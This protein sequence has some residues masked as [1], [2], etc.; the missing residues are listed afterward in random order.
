[1]KLV[2]RMLASALFACAAA[3]VTTGQ[4]VPDSLTLANAIQFAQ[5]RNPEVLVAREQLAELKGTIQEVRSQAYPDIS[6]QGFGL[7]LRDPSIL[8][9][10]S[11]D[12][13]PDEF[14]SALVPRGANLFDVGVTVKQPLYSAGKV[15]AGIR[16]AE[17]GQREKEA[18]LEA[19]RRNVAFK[20]FQAFHDLLLAQANLNVVLET[21]R[22]R[23]SHLEQ[24]NNR[25]AQGVATETDVLRSQVNLAN[26]APE[27]LRAE[28][29]IRLARATLNNLIVVDLDAPTQV[30]GKLE[31][32]PWKLP[33]VAEIQTQALENRPEVQVA[34]RLVQEAVLLE[35]LAQAE[36][37][38]TVDLE[39]RFGYNV[40]DPQNLFHQDY[41]RWNITLN[42]RV[43]IYDGGRKAGLMAQA[44]ARKRAAEQNLAALENSIRL[45]IKAAA[46]EMQSSAEAI[47]A[48][49]LNV[50]Q[51]EKVLQMMQANYQYGAAT[52]LDVVDSEAA[53]TV[54]RNAVIVA[55]YQYELA[56][57]RLRLAAG[58]PILEGEGNR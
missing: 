1:M 48:A 12:E 20:V 4:T 32:R 19:V 13:L 42:F 2:V 17:E 53:L 46:D 11:F 10:A 58:M 29:S 31:Y 18:A 49:R 45:E 14:R 21:A 34:H 8:N 16:L 38:P 51:A 6:V 15:S 41:T 33:A 52:T 55:T 25:Y 5:E 9:S 57:G 30:E 3:A 44:A 36:K 28:N 40:R 22:Q 43:P 37:K 35:T 7:R 56:K 50:G 39:G 47:T 23:E 26:V 27:R 24:A 54:A